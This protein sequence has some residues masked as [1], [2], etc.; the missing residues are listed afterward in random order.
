MLPLMHDMSDEELDRPLRQSAVGM[1]WRRWFGLLDRY[2]A[3]DAVGALAAEFGVSASAIHHNAKKWDRR[4]MDRPDAVRRGKGP[5]PPTATPLADGRVRVACGDQSIAFD[6]DDPEAT[7]HSALDVVERNAAAGMLLE[8]Q[9][10]IV[11][12]KGMR[13]LLTPRWRRGRIRWLKGDE[14]PVEATATAP[15][16]APLV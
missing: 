9:R 13:D 2:A 3:G 8:T 6:R 12:T 1:T 7:D 11:V 16:G 14:E 15:V 4:K 10:A 5:V